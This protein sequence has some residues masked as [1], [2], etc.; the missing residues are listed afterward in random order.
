MS[1]NKIATKGLKPKGN[2]IDSNLY[3]NPVLRRKCAY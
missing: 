2:Y 3:T 1:Y